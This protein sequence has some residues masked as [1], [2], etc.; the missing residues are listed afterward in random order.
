MCDIEVWFSLTIHTRLEM[1]Y[2]AKHY[3]KSFKT[4]TN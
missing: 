3:W 2:G 4:I 1:L